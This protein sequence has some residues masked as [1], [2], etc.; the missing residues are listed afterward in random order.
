MIFKFTG[1]FPDPFHDPRVVVADIQDCE[2]CRA[3]KVLS[4]LPVNYSAPLAPL[5]DYRM[6][7]MVGGGEDAA[8]SAD[9]FV[10][11][12][13]SCSIPFGGAG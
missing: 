12:S 10:I 5:D 13:H 1:R 2:S 8:G 6:V 3:V 11:R 4:S 7:D 9:Y